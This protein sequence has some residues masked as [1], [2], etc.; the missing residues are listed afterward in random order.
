ML[1][2]RLSRGVFERRHLRVER[3][4]RSSELGKQFP[5]RRNG[6]ACKFLIHLETQAD[7]DLRD[8]VR[9]FIELHTDCL[10][11]S[12]EFDPQSIGLQLER[13]GHTIEHIS[14]EQLAEQLLSFARVGKQHP[15]KLALGKQHY[16]LELNDAET[17]EFA[18]RLGDPRRGRLDRIGAL[19]PQP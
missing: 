12:G 4:E 14:A 6:R 10:I 3:R 7:V 8:L 15:R 1:I 9:G 19:D 18:A 17:D 5:F 16:S 2:G 11:R 13:F